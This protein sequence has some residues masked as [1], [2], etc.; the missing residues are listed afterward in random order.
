MLTVARAPLGKRPRTLHARS[1]ALDWEP[2]TP[3]SGDA[4]M[5]MAKILSRGTGGPLTKDAGAP[6]ATALVHTA[7][8]WHDH[9]LRASDTAEEVFGL[10]GDGYFGVRPFAVGSYFYRPPGILTGP[11]GAAPRSYVT[12]LR[13]FGTSE[14]TA[15]PYDGEPGSGFD[16]RPLTDDHA[17][18][19]VRWVERLDSEALAWQPVQ[20]G[21]WGGA[22]RKWLSR[23]R[24]SGGGTVIIA[25]PPG[26]SGT[27]SP[28]HGNSEEFVLSGAVT[29][30]GQLFDA[31]GYASRPAGEAAGDYETAGG[32]R[33]ICFWDNDE[34]EAA[35]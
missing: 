15:V 12:T 29:A 1:D 2:F 4:P 27:G 18:W 25:L 22:D 5:A 19:P 16:T 3:P 17:D 26:W 24:S 14:R 32:A 10:V 7:P 8:G 30:G 20:G 34:F 21:P 9:A 33:L 35:T 13:R 23:N 11:R 28:A 31:W 6:V